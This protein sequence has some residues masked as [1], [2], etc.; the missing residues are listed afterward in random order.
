MT[1]RF[2]VMTALLLVLT[3]SL[4]WAAGQRAADPDA[5]TTL[6]VW[7][8]KYGEVDG[9]QPPMIEID[10]MFEEAFPNI[11][12]DHV[13]QP[14]D[15]YYQVLRAAVT[16]GSGPDVVMFHGGARAWEFDQFLEPLDSYI[17][18][19][20]HEVSEFTWAAASYQG[21]PDNPVKVVPLT[22]QGLGWYYSKPAFVQ[23]GLDPERAPKSRDEFL[24]AAQALK[25][26]G[27]TPIITGMA[28]ENTFLSWGLR[29]QTVNAYPGDEVLQW[30]ESGMNFSDPGFVE[31]VDFFDELHRREF[32][33]R[34][35]YDMPLFMEAI[36]KFAGGGGGFF[37]G[38]LSDIAHWKDFEDGLGKGNVG[39]FPTVNLPGQSATDSQY[40]QGVGIGYAIMQWSRN[41]DI[42]AEYLK[43]YGSDG[44]SVLVE[45]VGA[46]HPNQAIDLS[47]IEYPSL[48]VIMGYIDNAQDAFNT[49]IPPAAD[50]NA[51]GR[52]SQSWMVAGDLTARQWI[53]RANEILAQER[54][55]Q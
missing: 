3:V 54:A 28:P 17:E 12:I 40:L 33:D 35:A 49:W 34:Q 47:G 23:A 7:D 37:L 30:R 39:Y 16:A 15:E 50:Q 44:A 48:E 10:R 9:M 18:H 46:L 4:A 29:V 22:T 52:L 13:A 5:P 45:M 42:A 31:A 43:Y 8:F 6:V 55:Q 38:L 1:K 32:I 51:I 53:D 20:R 19:W 27:I 11:T 21:N 14:H 41:K 25:D 36:E 2:F 24:A 26:A